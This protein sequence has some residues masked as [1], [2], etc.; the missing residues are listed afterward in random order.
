MSILSIPPQI[1]PYHPVKPHTSQRYYIHHNIPIILSFS[2]LTTP[3]V[4]RDTRF[5]ARNVMPFLK[6]NFIYYEKHCG[7]ERP[8]A[9]Q[10]R[11]RV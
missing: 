7:A 5:S 8:L 9:K 1:S 6:L 11:C 10:W 2:D 4:H 3:V